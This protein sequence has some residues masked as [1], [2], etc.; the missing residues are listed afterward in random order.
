MTDPSSQHLARRCQDVAQNARIAEAWV[1]DDKNA[2]LVARERES[3]TRMLRKGALRAERLAKAAQRPMCVGVFGPSQAGKSY[4]VEV[5]ARPAEGPL[6]ARFDGLDPV[7]FLSE[8]NPIGEK[9]STGLVTRFTIRRPAVPTPPG[10]P[11]RL[12][13]LTEMDVVKILANSYFFD[14]DQTKESVPDPGRLSSAL[15]ALARRAPVPSGLTEDDVLDLE[16][17]CQKHF[18]GAR[19][20][21]ALGRFW[22]DA[23]RLVP[24]LDLAGRAELF[25]MLWGGHAPFTRIYTALADAIV[26]LGR[27]DEAFAPIAALIPRTGSILDVATLAGLADEGGD[28]VDL[29]SASGAQVRLPRARAAA[30]TAELQIEMNERP[31]P[32][33]DDTDLLDFPGARSRQKVHLEVFFEEKEDALK[34]TFLRGKIAYLFDRYV[35]EQELTSM[36]LCIRPSV[37]EVVTLPDLVNDWI[38][39]THGRTPEARRGGPTLLF[40]VLTWF[41]THFVDKAGDTGTEPGLRFRNRIEAS[42]LSYF[43]KAHSWPRRWTPDAPFSNTFWFRNPNYPAEAIIRYEDRRE[44]AFLDEKTERIAALREGFIGLPEAAEHFASPARAFDE[45]L[46]LND[47]GV[48]YIVEN[49]VPICHPQLKLN[50]ISGRLDEVARDLHDLLRRFYQDTDIAQRLEA[51]RIAADHLFDC[52][53]VTLDRGTFGSLLRTLVIDP[54]DLAD[55]LFNS[56]QGAGRIAAAAT[57]GASDDVVKSV[58]ARPRPGTRPAPAPGTPRPPSGPRGEDER[59]LRLANAAISRWMVQLRRVPENDAFLEMTGLDA[60]A[61]KTI[62][63]ELMSLAQRSALNKRIAEDLRTL[64]AFDKIEQSSDKVAVIA[65]TLINDLVGDFGLSRQPSSEHPVVV[66]HDGEREAFA[67]PPVVFDASGLTE[68]PRNFA[69]TYAVDWQHGFYKVLEDNAKDVAGI[70]IDLEQNAK[71]KDVLDVLR[72]APQA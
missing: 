69:E 62:V 15:S 11:V 42:L 47:G 67:A 18:G 53:D 43:G 5:L 2:D 58:P 33:F 19:L 25:S 32:F 55:F 26:K 66:T 40:L 45:A 52:L 37:M 44:V 49:L 71:L 1:N 72:P 60:E 57:G 56:L 61:A 27:P 16:E 35:A 59:E 63:N 10:F 41:D 29:R 38:G 9:E 48:G 3:L 20:L 28:A 31:R 22:E 7:D 24:Q 17:Y 64:L 50:Q 70:T 34:E 51:K 65:A 39:S 30:L 54:I 68:T 12:R 13:L 14:G 6:K 23:R 21:D 36:L 8:I 46:K 4:L